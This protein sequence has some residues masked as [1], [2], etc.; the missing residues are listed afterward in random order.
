MRSSRWYLFAWLVVML[1][2][3]NGQAADDGNLVISAHLLQRLQDEGRT[4]VLVR[5]RENA[6]PV[7]ASAAARRSP[8]S[9]SSVKHD[10]RERRQRLERQLERKAPG[11]L[12][13]FRHLP[14][15]ALDLDAKSLRALRDSNDQLAVFEDR[16]HRPALASSGAVIGSDISHLNGYT[17]EGSFVA[18]LDTGVAVDHE[19]FAGKIIEEACFSTTSSLQG[20]TTMCP[21]GAESQFGPGAAA[22]CTDAGCDHGTHVAGIAVGDGRLV[23]EPSGV[24]P[25]ADL[26]AIQVFSDSRDGPVAYTSDIIAAMEHVLDLQELYGYR[27]AAVNLSLAGDPVAT[28]RECDVYLGAVSPEK[29]AV[30]LLR[31]AG[32]A[33]VAAAG[34][35]GEANAFASPGCVSTAIGVGATSDSDA[36]ASYSNR[37]SWLSLFAPGSAVRSSTYAP[38]TYGNYSGTSMATPQVAGAIAVLRSAA[39]SAVLDGAGDV[40]RLLAAITATGV[41]VDDTSNGRTLPR[42]QLDD[43]LQHV[44]RGELPVMEILDNDRDGVATSGGFDL[45]ST[46]G[47]YRGRFLAGRI[48]LGGNAFR[49][50]LPESVAGPMTVQAWWPPAL[51]GR[52]SYA[53]FTGTALH[54]GV[55]DQGEGGD[56]WQSLGTFDFAA[57]G[58]AYIEFRDDLGE[59]LVVDAVR[60]KTAD[61]TAITTAVLPA[62]E[63]G[64]AY[65]FQLMAVGG[66]DPVSWSVSAGALPP[67]LSLSGGGLLSG[68]PDVAGSFAFSVTVTDA[69]GIADT[70]DFVLVV[71]PPPN[72]PPVVAV[73]SPADGSVVDEGVALTLSATASDAED[74][75]LGAQISW[76]SD[77]DGALG[78]G[79]T[80]TISNLSVGTHRLTASVSDSAGA[81]AAHAVSLTV[82]SVPV[83]GGG[84]DVDVGNA[85][86]F[87]TVTLL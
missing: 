70:V 84:G 55:I 9:K 86:D 18:V 21:N 31:N 68:V 40:S 64:Q 43:A 42:L 69:L 20:A 16:R 33:T 29:S 3:T 73:I 6:E 49:F 56:A 39:E 26:I 32:I 23:G 7:T 4:R 27:V 47:S 54:G 44:E 11:R 57:G 48:P 35:D 65:Q 30:D 82:V 13:S 59:R 25:D 5:L 78:S 1:L 2:A 24:A 76:S 14:L 81:T 22:P 10:W 79:A 71:A 67:G 51:G 83:G 80:R 38:A 87:S 8:G 19:L 34:N 45:F 17:G 60:V 62:A 75:D 53:L 50:P 52:V 36:V 72:T 85:I 63:S 58:P 46:V 12:R 28:A 74:G 77:R 61:M 37:A 66:T 41:P 15:V